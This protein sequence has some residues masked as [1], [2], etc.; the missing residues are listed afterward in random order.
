MNNMYN[1]QPPYFTQPDNEGNIKWVQGIE[2][3][4]SYPVR[5]GHNAAIFDSENDGI[6]Y[7]K[8]ADNIGFCTL[9]KFRY[10]E[11]I[12]S[13][14]PQPQQVQADLSEYVKKSELAELIKSML[15]VQNESTISTT[16]TKRSTKQ[17]TST[18]GKHVQE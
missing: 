10:E 17:S 16:D 14:N 13:A 9:R 1:F 11:V 4:K 7:I 8:V 6:F 15:G 12:E 5:A 3:A 2:G 18:N